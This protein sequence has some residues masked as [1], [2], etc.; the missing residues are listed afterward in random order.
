MSPTDYVSRGQKRNKKAAKKPPTPW[1]RIV[2][3]IC[4]VSAFVFGLYQLQKT[5]LNVESE[6]ADD[7]SQLSELKPQ[8]PTTSDVALT[9]APP[10]SDPLPTLGEEQWAFIDALPEY[11]VEVDIPEDEQSDRQFI[12]QCGSFRTTERAQELR[13]KLALQGLEA[14]ILQSEGSTGIWYRVVLGPYERKR[15][16]ERHR[17]QVRRAGINGCKIW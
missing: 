9:P 1:L 11:S 8:S 17:H 13:A 14:Q 4:V 6:Q 3:A 5:P 15:E 12:M 2:L 16:A 10:N 7:A